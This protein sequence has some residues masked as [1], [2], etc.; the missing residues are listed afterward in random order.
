MEATLMHYCATLVIL[1]P[2]IFIVII[3]IIIVLF[4]FQ[5]KNCQIW[6]ILQKSKCSIPSQQCLKNASS[7]Q[8]ITV[9]LKKRV[10]ES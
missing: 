6:I 2:S 8:V 1:I 9:F 7:A 10:E 3:I 4:P 5:E